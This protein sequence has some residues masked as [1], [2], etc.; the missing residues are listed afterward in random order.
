VIYRCRDIKEFNR[1][2]AKNNGILK[3]RLTAAIKRTAR[4]GERI[5]TTN[6]PKAFGELR[7]SVYTSLSTIG[8]EVAANIVAAPHASAVEIGSRPHWMPIEPLIKWV[9]LRGMQALDSKYLKKS[10]ARKHGNTTRHQARSVGAQIRSLST[11]MVTPID[12]AERVA[13]AIQAAIAAGGTHPHWFV[14]RSLPAIEQYLHEEI[15]KVVNG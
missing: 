15:S 2:L 12:A 3:R 7:D 14:K 1:L 5:I 9:K 8:N 11:K 10:G 13:L 6:T 4:R